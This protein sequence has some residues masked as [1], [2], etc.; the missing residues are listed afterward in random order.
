M[1]VI[2]VT[3]GRYDGSDAGTIPDVATFDDIFHAHFAGLV[4]L[5]AILGAEDP[6]NVVQE[7]FARLHLRRRL[8][9]DPLAATAYV[10]KTVIN[11]TRS[12]HRRKRVALRAHSDLIAPPGPPPDEA[13]ASGLERDH[14]RAAVLAL[15]RRQRE[16]LVLR[17]WMGLSEREIAD[18]LGIAAGSVKSHAARAMRAVE[19]AMGAQ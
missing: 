12:D 2:V 6:E 15:P 19:E 3:T 4:R 1:M 10:R 13:V 18:E 7:A 8:L 17:Y 9:R 11:R 5:A 14:V 16:V